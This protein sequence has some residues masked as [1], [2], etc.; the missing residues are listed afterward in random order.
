MQ[1]TPRRIRPFFRN[2]HGPLPFSRPMADPSSPTHSLV[3]THPWPPDG[4]VTMKRDDAASGQCAG[5]PTDGLQLTLDGQPLTTPSAVRSVA[6][7]TRSVGAPSPQS[8]GTTTYTFVKWSDNGAQTH[9]ITTP[10]SNKSY[11][12]TYRK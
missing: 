6:G 3:S 10:N 2:H 9:S 7:M 5:Q 11:K 12:A 4:D 8:M 1:S